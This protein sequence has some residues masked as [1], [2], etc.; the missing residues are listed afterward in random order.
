MTRS[1]T[2]DRRRFARRSEAAPKGVREYWIVDPAERQIEFLVN[3]AGRFVV[4]LPAG[5]EYRSRALPEIRLDL[6]AFW[7]EVEE[8]L[9][10]A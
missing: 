10:G 2:A 5:A 3:E 8:T 1:R 4:A 6:L 9:P 7:Q